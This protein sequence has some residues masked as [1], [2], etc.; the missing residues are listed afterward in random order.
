MKDLRRDM[1][2]T[3]IP[4]GPYDPEKGQDYRAEILSPACGRLILPFNYWHEPGM[5]AECELADIFLD[6]LA[7]RTEN[8]I[9]DCGQE[10]PVAHF[11][12]RSGLDPES[13]EAKA[14]YGKE[15]RFLA[16]MDVWFDDAEN[17]LSAVR[18]NRRNVFGYT[19]FSEKSADKE[20]HA[21]GS[22][23]MLAYIGDKYVAALPLDSEENR[24]ICDGMMEICR[25]SSPETGDVRFHE[26]VEKMIPVDAHDYFEESFILYPVENEVSEERPYHDLRIR[27]REPAPKM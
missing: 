25:A 12:E 3:F 17:F 13:P 9:E 5:I 2:I 10:N 6:R 18:E 20:G 24:R 4:D 26:I 16:D 8:A 1:R 7:T 23:L 11:A 15:Q 14:E 27:S 21:E 19:V 22:C